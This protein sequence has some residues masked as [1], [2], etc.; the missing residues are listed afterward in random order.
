MLLSAIQSIAFSLIHVLTCID[1][2]DVKITGKV[3]KLL[4]NPAQLHVHTLTFLYI[5]FILIKSI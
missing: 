5:T 3:C 4:I 1:I 2:I